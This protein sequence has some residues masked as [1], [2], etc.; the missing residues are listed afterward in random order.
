M[1]SPLPSSPTDC[2]RLTGRWLL[3]LETLAIAGAVGLTVWA[4]LAAQG[5]GDSCVPDRARSVLPARPATPEGMAN[6]AGV[7]C[8]A[9]SEYEE[10]LYYFRQAVWSL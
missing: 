3:A 2:A 1:R 8:A 6:N 5:H 7:Q 4:C 10:A 9:R